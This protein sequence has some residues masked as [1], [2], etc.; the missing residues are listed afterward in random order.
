MNKKALEKQ[1]YRIVGNHSAIKVCYW[2]R[3]CIREV[4][5]CYKNTFYGISSNLCVQMTPALNTCTLRC[6]W[7]WRDIEHTSKEWTGPIDDPKDIISGCIKEHKKVLLGFKGSS[8][9][10]FE[11]SQQPKHF[12]ISLSG[13][14]TFYPRLP[15][16]I[17]E[18]TKQDL[19]SFLVT[20]GTNPEMI[21]QLIQ[22]PPTQ[23]YLTLPA[24]N[25]IVYKS[26]CN[27]LI[28]DGWEKILQS[29][30]LL[31]QF[32]RSVVRLTLTKSQ[33]MLKPEEYAKLIANNSDFI[34]IKGYMYA[35]HSQARL[36][37]KC[38]PYHEEV[39]QFAQE[40]VKHNSNYE[41][42]NEKPNSRVVLLKN[43]N[44]KISS[45][46]NF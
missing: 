20:N 43:K 18:L 36:N 13:E 16:L 10:M 30:T 35:G 42:V 23:I 46:L 4:D 26:V 2:T 11:K 41:I 24:P 31:K 33:N 22:T 37:P 34:E 9:K 8:K 3:E 15:E 38:M 40:L 19:T 25:K 17:K 27:P 7:C 29:L 45:E 1:G 12:A 39:K 32:P 21:T 5:S 6:N 14:P 44:S 28:K